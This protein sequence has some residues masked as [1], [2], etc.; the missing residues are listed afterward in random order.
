MEN[1]R[2]TINDIA[3]LAGV[4]RST[5][6][7]ALNNNPEVSPETKRRIQEV[8]EEHHYH[9]ST[10]ARRMVTKSCN[11]IGLYIGERLK[12]HH[13]SAQVLQGVIERCTAENYDI[14]ICGGK[15]EEQLVGMYQGGQVEGFI[16]LNPHA[17]VRTYLSALEKEGIPYICTA[18]C[19]KPGEFCCVDINN[20]KASYD[21]M[22]YLWK[23]GHREFAFVCETGNTVE[24]IAYRFSGCREYL[25]LQGMRIPDKRIMKVDIEN[26][27]I[28]PEILK[29]W[30]EEQVTA[31]VALTD[32]LAMRVVDVLEKAQVKIPEDISVVGFDDLSE[33]LEGYPLTTIHQDFYE[34]GAVACNKMFG[35][36]KKRQPLKKEWGILSHELVYRESVKRI[37]QSNMKEDEQE[38]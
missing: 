8:I 13:A 22:R 4:S 33:V 1:K 20:E 17:S 21:M 19:G 15:T 16:V 30:K 28:Q 23:Q 25:Q 2:L 32:D 12:V 26:R 38:C 24:S 14:I 18:E 5:V 6:S 3:K 10:Y 31:V 9:P 27:K 37:R 34:K 35:Y 36:L 11:T 29:S 7:R